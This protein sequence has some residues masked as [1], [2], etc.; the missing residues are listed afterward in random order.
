MSSLIVIILLF[1]LGFILTEPIIT[2][3]EIID[4]NDT[5]VL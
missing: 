2:R 1:L 5:I 4:K 3:Y